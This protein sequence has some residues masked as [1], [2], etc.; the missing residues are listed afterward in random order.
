MR[1]PNHRQRTSL[2]FNI[3]P[4]IDVIFLLII[5]F[6]V[7]SHIARSQAQETVDLPDAVRVEDDRPAA[8]RLTVTISQDGRLSVR[9]STVTFQQLQSELSAIA[10]GDSPPEIR[11]R[12]DRNSQ[13]RHVE[14]ILTQ[15]AALGILDV[16]F[17]VRKGGE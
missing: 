14:P 6:L 11:I 3:T 8:N 16:K 12:G 7:A 5:F 9:D 2:R 15:C 17:A 4:L 13:F 1:T 10:G